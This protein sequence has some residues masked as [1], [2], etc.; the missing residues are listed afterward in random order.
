M[1]EALHWHR[2]RFLQSAA[3]LPWLG[4]LALAQDQG[5]EGGPARIVREY[6]PRNLEYP[7]ASLDQP[8]TPTRLFYVRNHF[9]E[10]ALD[11]STWRLKVEGAVEKPLE[12][13]LASLKQLPR[14]ERVVTLECA[15][16]GRLFLTPTERGVQWDTGA[17]GTA[18][19]SGVS[20]GSVLDLA[21]VKPPAVEVVLEGADAGEVRSDPRSPG[22]IAFARSLPLGKARAP[23]VLLAYGMNGEPL[24]AAH[25]F[26]L[27]AVVG[28][29][30][31]MASIK[32]LTRI[33]VV[34][35]PF[36]GFYQSLDYTY[37]ERQ[38]GLPTLKPITAMQVKSAIARPA[39]GEVVAAGSKYV[40]RGAAWA[41]ESAVARVELSTDGGKSW[42]P[43]KLSSKPEPFVWTLWTHEWLVPRVPGTASLMVR[44]TDA[45][46]RTQ[47]MQRDPDR[48]NYVITHVVPTEVQIR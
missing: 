46:G 40:V 10:P 36:Q 6:Q 22:K 11:A 35:Q 7:F 9:P 28:G 17:I 45:Q 16:N 8:I 32:W 33:L 48:R 47:P 2:R 44:A 14:V 24:P 12:L 1:S 20:L 3:A 18:Q 5:G 38:N 37:W 42:Q 23:E 21:K 29:W 26:P 39:R 27:R 43:V 4:S 25:G 19:W 15:G 13:D 30:Y 41:G 31:G 34:E